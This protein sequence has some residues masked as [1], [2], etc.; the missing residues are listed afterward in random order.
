[1][2]AR[3]LFGAIRHRLFGPVKKTMPGED[4]RRADRVIGQL[5]MFGLAVMLV[6][7]LYGLWIPKGAVSNNK[8]DNVDSMHFIGWALAAAAMAIMSGGALG[9]LFGLPTARLGEVRRI[10]APP[11]VVPAPVAPPPPK[12]D[13]TAPVGSMAGGAPAIA[14]PQQI[15]ETRRYAADMPYNEST[16]LEQIADWLTKII[17]GLTLTQYASWEA[18][19]E[20]LSRNLTGALFNREGA[21]ERCIAALPTM[22]DDALPAQ[23]AA[24]AMASALCDSRFGSVVPGAIILVTYALI[25]L[26]VGYLW[27]RRHFI[28]EMVIARRNAENALVAE[29]ERRRSDAELAR[30]VAIA[31]AGAEA[32]R[33]RAEE[34]AA[35]AKAE[36]QREIARREAR[37]T[38]EIE[39][40]KSAGVA[41]ETTTQREATTPETLV[42]MVQKAVATAPTDSEA[43][44]TTNLIIE[45]ATSTPTF[46]DDPWRGKMGG[47]SERDGFKLEGAVSTTADPALFEV[48]L[49]VTANDRLKADVAGKQ[50]VQ[51]FLHPALGTDPRSANFDT[52]GVATL[53]L[54]ARTAFTAGAVTENGTQLEFNLASIPN[55]PPL[56]L[57]R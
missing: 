27:M 2:D 5:L 30:T 24:R 8:L 1:M 34:D 12:D 17:I 54:L 35:V 32:A 36:V 11:P 20:T 51:F 49:K 33:K 57:Q 31:T 9:A 42:E 16:S 21:I 7:I 14:G 25:G 23:K 22:A 47:E 53:T 56:F 41:V 4:P 50:T 38:A 15:D 55:A 28:T 18:R 3:G 45:S 43:H 13:K 40:K 26:M 19:F 39:A 52:N 46:P 6:L 48:V 10:T 37:F 29:S 44:N